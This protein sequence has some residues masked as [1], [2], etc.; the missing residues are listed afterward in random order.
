MSDV[1]KI[2]R[3]PRPPYLPAIHPQP[4]YHPHYPPP[5]N[6][7]AEPKQMGPLRK[8]MKQMMKN[9]GKL[10]K[11]AQQKVLQRRNRPVKRKFKVL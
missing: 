2:P 8:V 1:A 11:M 10:A 5:P 7:F 6:G 9:P 3:G 4:T